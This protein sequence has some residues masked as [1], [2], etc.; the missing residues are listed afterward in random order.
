M[1]EISNQKLTLLR[2]LNQKKYRQQEALFIV[3]GAR[4]V[5]QIIKNETL[6]VA[7]L[8]FDES[9]R[10]WEQNQWE[11][12]A[13]ENN[14]FT[15][16]EADFAEVSDTENPQGVLAV[17]EIPS[18]TSADD[19]AGQEGI[20]VAVDRIQDPGNLGTIIRTAGWFGARGLLAGKG[21]VDIFHPKVVRSTA[22]ATG[23]IPYRNVMLN[24]ELQYFEEAGWQNVLLDGG[25]HAVPLKKVSAAAKTV[26]VVGNE[27]N[28]IDP[29]L[30][31]DNRTVAKIN[32]QA[33]HPQVESLN[34]AIALSIA[35]Y[36]LSE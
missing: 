17:C 14:A 25:D 2:K 6:H 29:K 22:G 5:Q 27:A 24:R 12:A 4:A 32:S 18:E 3:E 13:G 35:L 10:Y 20:I 19:L 7:G 36:A 34:A 30:F 26:I 31:T 23:T 21:T 33:S 8:Y 15:V 16:K 1:R 9:Q 28:G 11:K